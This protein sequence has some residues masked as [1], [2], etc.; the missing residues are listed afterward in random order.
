MKKLK[1]KE[2]NKIIILG[3]LLTV[4]I[5]FTYYFHFILKTEVVFTHLFYVP[6]TFAGLWWSRKGIAV[7]VFLAIVLPISRI[8]SPLETPL[9]CTY[10]L[11][12]TGD[13]E[14]SLAAGCTGYI[15]KPINPDIFIGE[16][17]KYF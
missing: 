9:H 4:C 1:K 3:F 13:R 11:C 10:F 2:L 7:A 6:I 16:I 8:L 12:L 17:E 5:L 15:E 14:K